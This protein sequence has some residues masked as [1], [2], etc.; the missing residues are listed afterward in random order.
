LKR[1]QIDQNICGRFH[2]MG[3]GSHAFGQLCAS[4]QV[5]MIITTNDFGVITLAPKKHART[6]SPPKRSDKAS[7]RCREQLC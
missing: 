2:S 5:L 3:T 4:S 6:P 1:N 7:A